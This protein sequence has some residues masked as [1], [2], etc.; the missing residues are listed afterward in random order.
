MPGPSI[1]LPNYHDILRASL[2]RDP[3]MEGADPS[4]P[5]DANARVVACRNVLVSQ[6]LWPISIANTLMIT[7]FTSIGDNSIDI[8]T[9]F[10]KCR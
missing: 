2:Q 10:N 5:N 3:G 1:Q 6:Y 7:L 4:H 8:Y 9:T